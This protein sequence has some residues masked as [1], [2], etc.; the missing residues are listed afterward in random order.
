MRAF[1]GKVVIVPGVRHSA[2]NRVGAAEETAEAITWLWADSARFVN[3]AVLAV[4]GGDTARL[5]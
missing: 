2:Q 1:D 5:Y 4:D 3:G